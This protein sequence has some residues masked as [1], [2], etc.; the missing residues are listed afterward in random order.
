MLTA[1]T[2]LG[3]YR[4]MP[5]SAQI[6]DILLFLLPGFVAAEVF[7]VLTAYPR[8][9]TFERIVQA[10]ILTTIIKGIVWVWNRAELF[11]V[12]SGVEETSAE[13]ATSLFVA[14]LFGLGWFWVV[15]RNVLGKWS[16]VLGVTKTTSRPSEWYSAFSRNAECL[17]ILHLKDKRR[18][19][20]WPI[21]WPGQPD[22]GHFLIDRGV[23]LNGESQVNDGDQPP[24]TPLGPSTLVPASEVGM[25]EFIPAI[26]PWSDSHG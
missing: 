13:I 26:S 4:E 11:F 9:S 2:S 21:E 20:G 25:V 15:N 8:P 1:G 12:G 17:V 16:R 6:I 3:E 23:W 19:Y 22:K 10:L 14:I 7:Y 24:S 5:I 18:I